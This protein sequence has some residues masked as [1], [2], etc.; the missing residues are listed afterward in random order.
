MRRVLLLGLLAL[1]GCRVDATLDVV[2]NDDGSGRVDV[3]VV[4][5]AEAAERI[6][7]LGD[8]LQADDLIQTGW[9]VTGPDAD[10]AGGTTVTV[11]KDFF[12][13]DQAAA[14]IGE[15]TG[16]EGFLTDVSL[17]RGR[18][19]GRREFAFDATLDLTGG[20]DT[21]G[22]EALA[23]VLDGSPVGIDVAALEE[24]LGATVDEFTS[25]TLRVH[26]PG[27]T[28]FNE[29]DA[30]LSSAD[31]RQVFTWTA[32]L[33]DE[34]R[35]VAARTRDLDVLPVA[36]AGVTAVAVLVGLGLLVAARRRST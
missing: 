19:F 1:T 8:Q 20:V 18:P 34:A 13:P 31:G 7:D 24:E 5:D 4:L 33:G 3:T 17:E 15:V 29:D 26:L 11:S 28:V 27:G 12:S 32:G 21:L 36:L 23:D 30:E 16:P 14:V 2:V 35:P 9:T 10:D 6:P 25:F 22:D